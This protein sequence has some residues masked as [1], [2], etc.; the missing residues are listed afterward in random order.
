[1]LA[2]LTADMSAALAVGDLDAARV[3]HEAIGGLMAL[4]LASVDGCASIIAL[5]TEPATRE[6]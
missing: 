6:R 5:A 2:H 4:G 1:M 3:A